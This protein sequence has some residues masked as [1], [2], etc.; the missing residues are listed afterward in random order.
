MN[1]VESRFNSFEGFTEQE[2]LRVIAIQLSEIKITLWRMKE[3]ERQY[4]ET[5]RIKKEQENK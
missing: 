3:Q 5:W 1:D 4:W 2:M